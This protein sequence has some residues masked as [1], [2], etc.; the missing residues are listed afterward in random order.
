MYEWTYESIGAQQ[1]VTCELVQQ[2]KKKVAF[3]MRLGVNIELHNNIKMT[4]QVIQILNCFAFYSVCTQLLC[5]DRVYKK[6]TL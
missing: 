4:F 6:E 1:K 2:K 3:L 5:M